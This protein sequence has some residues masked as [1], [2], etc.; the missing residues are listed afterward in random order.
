[1]TFGPKI[2]YIQAH[3]PLHF[4]ITGLVFSMVPNLENTSLQEGVVCV[5]S[6]LKILWFHHQ[7][8]HPSANAIH[9]LKCNGLQASSACGVVNRFPSQIITFY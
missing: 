3:R 8:T 2:I 5:E 6:C 4:G 7:A 9:N 1:M